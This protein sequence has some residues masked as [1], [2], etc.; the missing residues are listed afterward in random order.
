MHVLKVI[1]E[2]AQFEL[3]FVFRMIPVIICQEIPVIENSIEF[4]SIYIPATINKFN[5]RYKGRGVIR[6]K[7]RRNT[8]KSRRVIPAT[9]KTYK[10]QGVIHIKVEAQYRPHNI[11]YSRWQTGYLN[12]IIDN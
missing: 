5:Y 4:T 8:Y 7:N 11:K 10:S 2:G 12:A 3:D 6:V 1:F 9:I